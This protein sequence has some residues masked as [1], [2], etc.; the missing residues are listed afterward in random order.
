MRENGS[1]RREFF[2][3]GVPNR[4]SNVRTNELSFRLIS[5]G[6]KI[7]PCQ[8]EETH[9]KGPEHQRNRDGKRPVY[10]LKIKVRQRQYI[11]IF[12]SL[13]DQSRH[14]GARQH[15]TQRHRSIRQQP[16]NKE[17]NGDTRADSKCLHCYKCRC[18]KNKVGVAPQNQLQNLLVLSS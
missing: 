6:R 11:S 7:S 12:Q 1:V 8:E 3:A 9:Q 13:R 5:Q 17:I 14:D 18:A 4:E 2:L 16:V 10:L 15:S